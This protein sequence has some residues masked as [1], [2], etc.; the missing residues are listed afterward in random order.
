LID[1]TVKKTS[2]KTLF[3]E[4]DKIWQ[5]GPEVKHKFTKFDWANDS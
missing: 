1:V 4:Y 3:V 2:N 5:K